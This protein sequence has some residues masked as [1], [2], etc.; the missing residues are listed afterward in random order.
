MPT[1]DLVDLYEHLMS[2][3]PAA[4]SVGVDANTRAMAWFH[5]HGSGK[6]ARTWRGTRP[7]DGWSDLLFNIVVCQLLHDVREELE[8]AGMC[9]DVH[10]NGEHGL[11]ADPGD[12]ATAKAFAA[13]WADDLAFMM[14]GDTPH[15]LLDSVKLLASEVIKKFQQRGLQFNFGHGKTEIVLHLRGER[16]TQLRRQLFSVNEPTVAIDLEGRN[17]PIRLVR[18]YT[19]LGGILHGKGNMRPE[20][21]HRL[22]MARDAFQQHRHAVYQQTA[23]PLLHRT[24]IFEACVLS[25]AYYGA[26]T[27]TAL[28]AKEEIYFFSGIM[29]LYRRQ[30]RGPRATPA[31]DGRTS[32]PSPAASSSSSSS[33]PT[34]PSPLWPCMSHW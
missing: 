29:R 25:T 6:V 9:F 23:L 27:W 3:P 1:D 31:L 33:S 13:A 16:S 12:D 32:L 14:W 4:E 11:R 34:A 2:S 22:A 15:L 18:Q 26:G 24:R 8:A 28:V 5:V 20:L 17:T 19:H 7:G 10:W 21:R 30:G